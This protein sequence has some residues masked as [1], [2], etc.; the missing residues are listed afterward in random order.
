MINDEGRGLFM[1]FAPSTCPALD[2]TRAMRGQA[3]RNRACLPRPFRLNRA[4][5]RTMDCNRLARFRPSQIQLPSARG[6]ES[7][8][9]R[10]L[11]GTLIFWSLS[12]Y[13]F[14]FFVCCS[15]CFSN[16]NRRVRLR[17]VSVLLDLLLLQH[18]ERF[19]C[20]VVAVHILIHAKRVA[21]FV[22]GESVA[23]FPRPCHRIPNPACL[24]L[25]H[26]IK[27]SRHRVASIG[28]RAIAQADF[29]AQTAKR[30]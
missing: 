9:P 8:R 25:Q 26:R 5:A 11:F 7:V 24:T 18:A 23:S 29:T 17:N 6:G 15:F 19:I 4:R 13:P 12:F 30:R 28:K 16:T 10:G 14:D 21:Q 1:H 2:P 20:K 22:A 3:M 27:K